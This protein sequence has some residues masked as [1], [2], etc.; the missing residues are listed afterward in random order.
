MPFIGKA[1]S[2][3]GITR[4]YTSSSTGTF[5]VNLPNTNDSFSVVVSKAGYSEQTLAFNASQTHHS[6]TL[7][8]TSTPTMTE[9]KP[10]FGSGGGGSLPFGFMLLIGLLVLQRLRP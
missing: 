1:V 9:N 8:S 2:A 10:K 6:V 5:T 3:V 4:N 7:T